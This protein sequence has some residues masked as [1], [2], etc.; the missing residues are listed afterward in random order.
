MKAYIATTGVLFL[1][2]TV[3]HVWR[4]VYAEPFLAKEPWYLLLTGL[5]AAL[6]IWAGRL[7]WRTRS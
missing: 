1:L 5:A 4:M 2:I 6:G 7:L 3:A